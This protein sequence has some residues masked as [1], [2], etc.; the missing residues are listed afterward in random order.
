MRASPAIRRCQVKTA[1]PAKDFRL[2][3]GAN[4]VPST[5]W[6]RCLVVKAKGGTLV[7]QGRGFGHGVG[8]PQV[9][10]WE[11]ARSGVSADDIVSRYYTGTTIERKY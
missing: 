4:L 6:D 11:L 7:L 3:V 5:W 9:S 10:A 2:A 8:L 1:I